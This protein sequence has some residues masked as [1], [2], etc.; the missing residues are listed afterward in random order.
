M[1]VDDD[2]DNLASTG[3]LTHNTMLTAGLTISFGGNSA[4]SMADRER[5][6]DRELRA[7]RDERDRVADR[8]RRLGGQGMTERE[9]MLERELMMAR[10]QL[11]MRETRMT[12]DS[13]RMFRDSSIIMT[14]GAGARGEGR[15]ITVPVPEQ[16]EIILRY[17]MP[18]RSGSDSAATRRDS[19]IVSPPSDDLAARLLE[20]ERRLTAR[21]D[22]LQQQPAGTPP[23]VT[24]V[25]PPANVVMEDRSNVPVFQRFGQTRRSDLQ[26]YLGVG[27]NDGDA[28]VIGGLRADLGPISPNSGFHFV[29]EL[30]VGIGSGPLSVLAMAN[31]QYKFGAI[32]GNNGIRPYATVGGGIFS[33]SVL[34]IN[35]AIGSSVSLRNDTDAPLLLNVELQGINL[36]NHTRILFG[37]SRGR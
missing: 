4:T 13:V 24:M 18:A 37:L 19:V 16:G 27:I 28:Q 23:T 31:V 12:R 11:E 34:G 7:L 25:T 36:F 6:R 9:R 8:D 29:P 33:P 22:A 1:T 17:G 30:A 21:I 15:W 10:E 35:T 3:D 20:I 5:D 26:P 32:G 2:L 14:R